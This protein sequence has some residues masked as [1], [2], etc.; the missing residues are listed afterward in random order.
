MKLNFKVEDM[1]KDGILAVGVTFLM[2]LLSKYMLMCEIPSKLPIAKG[3][4]EIEL[5]RFQI[6]NYYYD[7]SL[8]L[9]NN[10]LAFIIV[11]TG[12]VLLFKIL[13]RYIYR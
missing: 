2:S 4:T 1:Q 7:R 5:I 3:A 10:V 6:E 11:V 12:C 9:M 13:K 8:T